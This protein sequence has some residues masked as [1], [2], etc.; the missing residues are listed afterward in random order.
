[1]EALTFN[2]KQHKGKLRYNAAFPKAQIQNPDDVLIQVAYAGVC[3]T[4]LHIMEGHFPC[5]PDGD[6]VLGH[7]FSGRVVA[8]GAQVT[9]VK[10]GDQVSVDP[11]QGCM[12]CG[13]CRYG[14]VHYCRDGGLNNT[15]GIY[16]NGGFAQFV[17][18]PD[19]QVHK[20]PSELSLMQ[21]ALTEPLSCIVHGWDKL[22]PIPVGKKI[23][24]LGAGIIGNLWI[25]ILQGQGHRKITMSEV[26]KSRLDHI[27]KYFSGV[28][29]V[30]P[31]QLLKRVDNEES[32]DLVIDCSGNGKAIEQGVSVL[33]TGGTMCIFGVASPE[34]RISIAPYELFAK[35]LTI[36]GVKINPFTFPKALGLMQS[37]CDQFLVYEKLGIKVFKLSEFEKAIEDLKKGTIA[38]AMFHVGL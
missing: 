30:T 36:M 26:N 12:V 18:V 6:V 29:C 15:V 11:N 35:E 5:K 27:Q 10:V 16:R 23:L 4:D 33:K 28:E 17:V 20:L 32:F 14:N 34:T 24:I 9:N 37:L 38:K 22:Q 13:D 7:E 25:S 19:V 2:L 1:M 31:D 8:I 3:G 21:G